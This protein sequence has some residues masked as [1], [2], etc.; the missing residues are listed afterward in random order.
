MKNTTKKF[1][2]GLGI[3]SIFIIT[4]IFV[5][6]AGNGIGNQPN[7]TNNVSNGHGQMAIQ[8]NNSVHNKG[9][10]FNISS[11]LVYVVYG[12]KANISAGETIDYLLN[13][14]GWEEIDVRFYSD[15]GVDVDINGNNFKNIKKKDHKVK[16]NQDNVSISIKGNK[17][18]K[19][20]I[21]VIGVKKKYVDGKPKHPEIKGGKN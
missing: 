11:D 2:Y 12:F 15:D 17:K 8:A 4:A 7:E 1:L 3:F 10:K 16:G 21:V 6:G 20:G 13:T 18:G 14:T 9:M 5:I 19:Y